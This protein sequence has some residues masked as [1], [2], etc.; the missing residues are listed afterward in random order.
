MV[1]NKKQ[2]N[3]VLILTGGYGFPIGDAYTNRIL[4]FAKGF[5]KNNCKVTILIIYPGHNNKAEEKG[6]IDGAEFI[7]C[8][9]TK[10]HNSFFLRKLIGL[11]GIVN[12]LKFLTKINKEEKIDAV[13]T[14]SQYLSQNLF[15]YFF[16]RLKKIL[17]LRE[18]NEFPHV[19]LN[20][21][22][23]KLHFNEKLYFKFLNQLYDGYILISSSLKKFNDNL[24]KR[25]SP[26]LT[27]PIIVDNERFAFD[28][29]DR[30]NKITYCGNLFGDKDGVKILLEAFSLIHLKHPSYKLLLV[31]NTSNLSKFE[32]LKS[33]IIKLGI[34]NKVE[35]SGFISRDKIPFILSQSTLLV[36]ARPNNI[37]AKGGFPTKLG[38]YLA[39]GR[40]VLVTATSDIPNYLT[41]KKNAFLAQPDSVEDFALKMDEI[42]SEYEFAAQVGIEGK[43]LTENVFNY[44]FQA[45]RIIDFIHQLK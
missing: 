12:S 32:D 11:K 23:E 14:F 42:L 39:S 4:A 31:G 5:V 35:F 34:E 40:P 36:L 19:V 17:F 16:T 20:R 13:I 24:L 1:G 44:A 45:N 22:H 38:E 43:K 21:G 2:L 29:V 18:N 10:R 27:V 25:N 33:T 28:E 3:I 37:Q 15:I 6:S 8:A 26:V 30:L 7:F 9:G 41:H